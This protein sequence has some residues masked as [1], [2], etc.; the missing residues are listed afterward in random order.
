[1][2]MRRMAAVAA[3]TAGLLTA[4]AAPAVADTSA[5]G[6]GLALCNERAQ[7]IHG[8]FPQ[9]GGLTTT[10]IPPRTCWK[11]PL[12]S[13]RSNEQVVVYAHYDGGHMLAVEHF[14]FDSTAG[15]YA[16]TVH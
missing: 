11:S 15:W 10:L 9:R 13:G 2:R 8:E 5:A 4:L 16:R 7:S 14:F 1:M 6:G 3:L 12:I